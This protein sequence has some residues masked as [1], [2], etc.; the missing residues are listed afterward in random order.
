[1]KLLLRRKEGNSREKNAY[2]N[3]RWRDTGYTSLFVATGFLGGFSPS[4][5]IVRLLVDAGANTAPRVGIDDSPVPVSALELTTRMLRSKKDETD[6]TD[7]NGAN[8][9]E[10]QLHGLEGIRR[11]LLHG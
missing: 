4:L 6:G 10:D 2:A 7:G 8:F 5:R 3:F 1:M 9:K 11:L